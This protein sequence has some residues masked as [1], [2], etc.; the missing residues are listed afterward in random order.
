MCIRDS[1]GELGFEIYC[2]NEA[3]SHIWNFILE[4]SNS[5]GVKP[6]GLGSRDTLRLEMGYLLYGNDM[7]IKTTPFEAGLGWITSL[8]KGAFIGRDEIILKKKSLDTLLIYFVMIEKGIP[9]PG[10]DIIMK[11]EVIGH[12]TSGTIS[13]SLNK[14]IGI[15]YIKADYVGK[16][17]LI[18]IGIRGRNKKGKL[19]NAPFYKRGS[20]N[21]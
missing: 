2:S 16:D 7:N 9:R 15:G 20:L 18:S 8:N 13:P 1:T 10:F 6:A 19:V 5:T 3:A 14:G 4:D 21:N 11:D 12:V 17:K